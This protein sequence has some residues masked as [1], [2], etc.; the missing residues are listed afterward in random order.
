MSIFVKLQTKREKLY[1]MT[2]FVEERFSK[3]WWINW[4]MITV[5]SFLVA[6]GFVL[7]LQPYTIV[8]GGVYGAGIVLNYIFPQIEMGTFGLM[9]DI[10]L[11]IVAFLI[12][13]G[14]F[15]AKTI[16][17]AL[18]IPLFMNSMTYFIGSIDPTVMFDGAIDLSNE[19]LIA[20]AFGGVLVGAGVGLVVRTHAT[21]GGTDVIA[22]MLTK[23]AKMKFSNGILLVDSLVVVFGVVAVAD[24]TLPLYSLVTIFVMSR[25]INFIVGGESSNKLMFI[26]SERHDQLKFFILE[27]MGRGAT[28]IKSHGMYTDSEKE[29]V[30]LVVSINEVSLVRK[31]IKEI[32]PDSFVVI[33][34][35]YETYGDGFKELR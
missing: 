30:F 5:G 27:E 14:A 1:H 2:K 8:P 3:E 20:C 18:L 15:G 12:F 6:A 9:I 23:F 19:M 10:P 11:L 26:I 25:T 24:W 21:T 22:M 35:A 7:F 31:K 28:Y 33:V 32:D 4:L 13:G 17:S 29:M 16:V 34:D